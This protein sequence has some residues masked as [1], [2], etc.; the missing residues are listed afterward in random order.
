MPSIAL[1]CQAAWI[2]NGKAYVRWSDKTV[3]EFSSA[4]DL[5]AYIT[6]QLDKDVLRALALAKAFNTGVTAPNLTAMVGKTIT[7][8]TGAAQNIVRYA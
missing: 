7:G 3:Q 2:D 5:Q 6:N 4:A 1:T 8:D